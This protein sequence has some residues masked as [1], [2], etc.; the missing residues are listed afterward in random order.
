MR[1]FW[2]RSRRVVVRCLRHSY[3]RP[4]RPSTLREVVG[5]ASLRLA[6]ALAV[7]AGTRFLSEFPASPRFQELSPRPAIFLNVGV[8]SSRSVRY[9]SVS[10][11]PLCLACA[12]A[13][14]AVG[15]G[16]RMRCRPFSA[17]RKS[18]R[19]SIVPNGGLSSSR[20]FRYNSVR[21]SN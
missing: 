10:L 9:I 5:F 17:S 7:V 14:V 1:D 4:R 20:S 15:D 16:S 6:R 19:P 13:V 8:G 21:N 11:E 3:F 2:T 18:P 12:H